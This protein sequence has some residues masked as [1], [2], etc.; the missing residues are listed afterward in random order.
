MEEREVV[1]QRGI[2]TVE[3]SYNETVWYETVEKWV[4]RLMGKESC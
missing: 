4:R 3:Y 2:G 1:R